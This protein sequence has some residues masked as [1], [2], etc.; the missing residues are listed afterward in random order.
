RK[1][2]DLAQDTVTFSLLLLAGLQQAFRG[3]RSRV[4]PAGAQPPSYA[5]L[6]PLAEAIEKDL[7]G[8]LPLSQYAVGREF[9]PGEVVYWKV[10]L[11]FLKV[12]PTVEQFLYHHRDIAMQRGQTF[13]TY[14]EVLLD[15][16]EQPEILELL[17]RVGYPT[18]Q[19]QGS[20]EALEMP[21]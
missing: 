2:M 20:I 17:V 14:K 12:A 16:L 21:Q 1:A 4:V 9:R 19:V 5:V 6:G 11:N 18:V 15:L 10:P 7:T 3:G 8:G 13:T